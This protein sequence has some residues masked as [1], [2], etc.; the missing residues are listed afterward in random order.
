MVQGS[1]GGL[2][3]QI[4]EASGATCRIHAHTGLNAS[5]VSMKQVV[6]RLRAPTLGRPSTAATK[7]AA[8]CPGNSLSPN[9]GSRLLQ[10]VELR[11]GSLGNVGM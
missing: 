2:E 1:V 3:L 7:L 8:I 9:V 4:S 11:Q 10:D 5:D 6:F